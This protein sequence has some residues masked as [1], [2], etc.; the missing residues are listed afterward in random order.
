M[1]IKEVYCKSALSPSALSGIDYSL[2]PYKGCSH[3]CRYCYVPSVL[4][5]P[6]DEWGSWV[7]VRINIPTVLSKELRKKKKGVVGISTVTDPYQYVE[8]KYKLTRYCLQELLKKDFPISL[9]TKSDLILRDVE[10]IERFKDV[11]VGIT[12]S[13]MMDDE[14]KL[15]EPNAPP[16]ERRFFALKELSKKLKTY[17][18]LGPLYPTI[19][20]E[21]VEEFVARLADAGVGIVIVDD[22]HLK[23]GVWESIERAL[24][25]ERE[26]L[27]LFK[28]RLFDDKNYYPFIFEQI[29][30]TCDRY[31]LKFE[32]EK[33]YF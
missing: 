32:R 9:Q 16:I 4:H 14:R 3:A 15:L 17:A 5:L 28:K 23:E 12:I 2:N 18:F 26:L 1:K 11:E 27:K 8:K 22:L 19:E 29:K 24:E 33:L 25:N 20:E 31:G 7:E 13:T 30:R 6:R 21:D 10:L